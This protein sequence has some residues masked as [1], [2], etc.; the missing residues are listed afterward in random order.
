MVKIGQGKEDSHILIQISTHHRH[1]RQGQMYLQG[2]SSHRE[3][4]FLYS[5][6]IHLLFLVVVIRLAVVLVLVQPQCCYNMHVLYQVNQRTI[7]E[8]LFDR[9]EE[10]SH[11]TRAEIDKVS[12]ID[13]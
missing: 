3:S 8:Q 4:H 10:E 2:Y 7:L 1:L 11:E 9:H 6:P 13:R 5:I 12:R